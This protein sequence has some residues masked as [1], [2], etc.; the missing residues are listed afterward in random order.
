MTYQMKSGGLGIV[1]YMQHGVPYLLTL[2]GCLRDINGVSLVKPGVGQ[3]LGDTQAVKLQPYIFPWTELVG[4]VSVHLAGT[5]EKALV[6]HQIVAPCH[7]VGA[8]GIQKAKAG[9]HV[10]K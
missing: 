8:G 5:N 2:S 10:M 1:R 6:F 9:N 4:T 7:P 3:I